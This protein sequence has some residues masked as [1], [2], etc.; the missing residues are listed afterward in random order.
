MGKMREV[1]TPIEV[2]R[3]GIGCSGSIGSTKSSSLPVKY[4]KE[5]ASL[6]G[7]GLEAEVNAPAKCNLPG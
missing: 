1:P 4:G 2:P 7:G 5:L 3:V 6:C